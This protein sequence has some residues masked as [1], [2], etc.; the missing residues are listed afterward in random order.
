[1]S[2]FAQIVA[3]WSATRALRPKEKLSCTI[4]HL[5]LRGFAR[6]WRTKSWTDRVV[7]SA[8]E[9]KGAVKELAGKAAGDAKLKSDGKADKIGGK[10]QNAIGGVKDTL[11]GK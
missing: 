2:N 3:Q 1:M 4:A 6:S 11:K 8:K 7:G 9:F 5:P 10:V